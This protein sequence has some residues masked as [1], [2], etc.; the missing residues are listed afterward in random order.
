MGEVV[1]ITVRLYEKVTM[2]HTINYLPKTKLIVHLVIPCIIYMYSFN[3]L[4]SSELMLLSL[5]ARDCL[6]KNSI[7]D[8]RSS[9]LSCLP[10][11][12]ERL[13]KQTTNW[14]CF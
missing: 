9:C 8:A 4:F 14:N 2:N 3:K 7:A 5:R 12:S 10:G 6:T 1:K 11:L 13:P